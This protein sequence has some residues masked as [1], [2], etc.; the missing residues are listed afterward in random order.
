MKELL[1]TKIGEKIE[2]YETLR[3]IYNNFHSNFY[4]KRTVPKDISEK[5][6]K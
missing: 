6:Y 1:E 3:N 4:S 5:D 2:D